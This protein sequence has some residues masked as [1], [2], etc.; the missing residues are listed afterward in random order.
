M[1]QDHPKLE[2]TTCRN[3]TDFPL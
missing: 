3:V 1:K 2:S